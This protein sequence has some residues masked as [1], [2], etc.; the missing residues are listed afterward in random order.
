MGLNYYVIDTETTGLS[1][2]WNEVT[3]ISIIRCTDRR[4]LTKRVKA[5]FP[6]R[7]SEKAL[8]IT[9]RSFE[10][11][12]DG[13]SKEDVIKM[14]NNFFAQDNLT[15]EHRCIIAH[16]AA[17]D[18]RFCHALW[19]SVGKEFPAICWMDT[20]KFAKDWSKQ[21]GALPE[22]NTKTGKPSFNLASV[23]KFANITP[24]PG[25]HSAAPDA[26]NTY[27]LWKKG[28]DLNIDHLSSIKRYP[29]I[30]NK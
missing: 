7:A 13:D 1:A 23:L 29:H 8:E 25:Q 24:M 28:T 9:G 30:L 3:E 12:L 15:P 21:I 4:Q 10:S 5:E 14:C 22:T 16:N 18:K 2:G 17:F 26:R 6:E 20:I 11:L 19:E 27:L